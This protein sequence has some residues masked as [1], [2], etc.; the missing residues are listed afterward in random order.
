MRA[1]IQQKILLLLLGLALPPLVLVGWLG[2]AG[3]ARARDTAVDDGM[4]A[5]RLQAERTLLDRAGDKARL[6]DLSLAAIEQQVATVA[7]YAASDYD[8]HTYTMTPDRVWI[9]PAPSPEGV[10]THAGQVAFVQHLIPLLRSSVQANELVSIGYIALDDGGVMAFDNEGVID[11][12]LRIQ[13]FDP[14][15]RPWYLA[16]HKAGRTVWT[17]TYVDANTGDLTTTCATPIYD[18]KGRFIGVVA[19]DL[20]LRTIQQD[21]LT[22]DIG[23]QG[24]AL[25]VN[26]AGTVIVR[27]DLEARGHSW[28]QP[29]RSENLHESPSSDLREIA[30]AMGARGEGVRRI[31]YA[32][33]PSYI[34]YAPIPTAGWAVALVL[35]A[36]EV[37][38]PAI[39]TGQRIRV[40][41]D[42]LQSQLLWMLVALGGVISVLGYLLSLSFSRRI[43][44]VYEGVQAVA[45]GSL[46]RRLPPVGTDEIGQLAEAFN[47]MAA[48]LQGKVHELEENARQ[49]GTLNEVS[50][51]L[52]GIL[53][54]HQLHQAIPRAVCERFG[55]DRAVLYLVEGDQLRVVAASF[56]PGGETQARYYIEVANSHP[57]GLA[58]TSIEADVIRSRKA[59][60]VDNPWSHPGVEPHKQAASASHSYVQVPI[61]GR[62][63]RAI[64]II[65]AD[66]HISRRPIV[67]ED[68]GRLLTFAGVVGLTIQNVQLYSDLERQV[69][70][71]TEELRAALEQAQ[72]AD[73]RKSDFL[74]SL[75]HE[76]RT[77]LNA[78]IGF[79]TVM[80]D[81]LDGPLSPSQRED[82]QS[83]NRN[84]RFLLHLITE[85]LDLARIEA[86]HLTLELGVVDLR[87]LIGDVVDTIQGIVR[88]PTACAR[89]C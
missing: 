38:Q 72:L 5:L 55:F 27:P 76:L 13:P 63:G 16:A 75:S 10:L 73:R 43:K 17:D 64:G 83:I 61:F 67:A 35:P 78:I 88:T 40:G 70:R 32:D 12:L 85:L 20:L 58:G 34:A 87:M 39:T 45:S 80:L 81:D 28:D 21:L 19:F 82:M 46:D 2:V 26:E 11:A 8:A 57:L 22:V 52:K 53:Q 74:A 47:T 48:A 60:I 62:E 68:A 18:E 6:Y 14:R 42:Y 23:D 4:T 56:G 71:R 3:L 33:Q 51:E 1:S 29:F 37:T 86:G 59:I 24:L 84:G 66:C 44:T 30:A 50:N 31:D 65:S 89:S 49:L 41:Q 7:T 69:A 9:A 25:L 36:D 54:L 77:P 15:T 79:S